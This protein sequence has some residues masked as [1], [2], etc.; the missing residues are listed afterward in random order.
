[1]VKAMPKE[2]DF[3][4]DE[5]IDNTTSSQELACSGDACELP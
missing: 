3:K 4:F 1:M 2:I 5:S